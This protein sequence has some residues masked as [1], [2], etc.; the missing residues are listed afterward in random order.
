MHRSSPVTPSIHSP[1]GGCCLLSP[2][3]S[4]PAL[5]SGL[6]PKGRITCIAGQ[7]GAFDSIRRCVVFLT[8]QGNSLVLIVRQPVHLFR[9]LMDTNVRS[10]HNSI[11][12]HPEALRGFPGCVISILYQSTLQSW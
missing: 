11:R 7:C 1:P 2:S 5:L 8:Q 12:A 4:L 6:L 3:G 9:L 10:P